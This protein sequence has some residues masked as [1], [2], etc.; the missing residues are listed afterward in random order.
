MKKVFLFIGLSLLGLGAFSQELRFTKGGVTA[1]MLKDGRSYEDFIGG[2]IKVVDD[3]GTVYSFVKA[4]VDVITRDGKKIKFSLSRPGF[5]E[6]Q[7]NKII[8]ADGEGTSYIFRNV[9]V[10]DN[11]GKEYVIAELKYEFPSSLRG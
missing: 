3:A 7:S 11:S 6:E 10:K 2:N 4:D 5:N 1:G 8:V 9:T